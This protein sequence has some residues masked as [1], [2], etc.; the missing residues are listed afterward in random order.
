MPELPFSKQNQKSRISGEAFW[1]LNVGLT[2]RENYSEVQIKHARGLDPHKVTVGNVLLR[3]ENSEC[4][5]MHIE[6]TLHIWDTRNILQDIFKHKL[7]SSKKMNVY[8][9]RI[10][11]SFK[12]EWSN[13]HLWLGV[14]DLWKHGPSCL[15][16]FIWMPEYYSKKGN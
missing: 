7:A 13:L 6:V 10:W 3:R 5:Q 2:L 16:H 14:G 15:L 1:F 12:V 11:K 4:K 8:K 9:Y